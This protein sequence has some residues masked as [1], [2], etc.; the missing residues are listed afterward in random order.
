MIFSDITAAVSNVGL[1]IIDMLEA[2]RFS[3]GK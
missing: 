2:C 1:H 3:V